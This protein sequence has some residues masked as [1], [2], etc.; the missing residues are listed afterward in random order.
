MDK[1]TQFLKDISY[2]S[3]YEFLD[4]GKHKDELSA[5]ANKRGIK[6]PAHDLA[7]FKCTY[8]FVNRQNLNG[9][10]LPKAEVERTLNTLVGKAVDF[11]HL[12]QR[13]VGHWID[14]ELVNDEIIAYG[15]F[16]K[17][18]FEEDYKIIKDLM[19]KDVLSIS[20]EAYGNR[21]FTSVNS[22][23]LTDIEFSGGALLI[24]T[25]PA[26]PGSEV[27]EMAKE[28][29]LEFAKIM[30]PPKEYFHKGIH[31][32]K[33]KK[34]EKDAG[35][36][37]LDDIQAIND[38]LSSVECPGCKEKA[39][40]EIEM[41]DLEKQTL[42]VKCYNCQ[43][44]VKVDLTPAVEL[45]KKGKKP[46]AESVVASI[47]ETE[48]GDKDMTKE[49]EK[50]KSLNDLDKT[51]PQFTVKCNSCGFTFHSD[52]RGESTPCKECGGTT[53]TVG[54][55]ASGV[56]KS[57]D[58]GEEKIM[59]EKIEAQEKEIAKLVED[60]KKATDDLTSKATELEKATATIEELKKESNET[61]VKIE[62][63]E[64]ASAEKIEK[65]TADATKVAE[66]KAILGEEAS[67]G[68]DLLND[69]AY[70][71]AKAKKELSEKEAEI[72]ELKKGK[73]A[74]AGKK[75]LD[76]GSSTADDE[77]TDEV[78]KKAKK[79]HDYFLDSIK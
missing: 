49:K 64:K 14:A 63:V 44:V 11:D 62:E 39:L 47:V 31:H 20:F 24:K 45:I 68:V 40:G 8:G 36:L 70:E 32:D 54:V 79:V 25:N 26:F 72:A 53:T 21:E 48:K 34:K 23:N 28:R 1:I 51:K 46:T 3:K 77:E 19:E 55:A 74:D 29:V 5:I 22:Y 43:A 13:V 52:V 30:T 27:M 15:I 65:A 42:R 58:M 16:F 73:P 50:G 10:T 2:N 41:L 60:L 56:P 35:R 6:L 33:K 37:Y 76:K 67:E 9:C 17:G 59:K 57:V 12:R 4:E 18:N 71:L 7:V 66:R 78:T 61:K 75:P 69:N 38:L